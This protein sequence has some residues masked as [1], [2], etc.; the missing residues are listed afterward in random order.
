MNDLKP[1]KHGEEGTHYACAER[2]ENLGEQ[3]ACC[4]C[5]GH[6][7][8]RSTPAINRENWKKLYRKMTNGTPRDQAVEAFIEELLRSVEVEWANKD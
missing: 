1:F 3:V 7:C 2:S 6:G 8:K 4:G 5:L